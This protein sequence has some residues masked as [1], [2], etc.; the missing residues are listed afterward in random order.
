MAKLH[1]TL[2][3]E[4]DVET[5]NDSVKEELATRLYEGSLLN[6]DSIQNIIAIDPT[7]AEVKQVVVEVK[8]FLKKDEVPTL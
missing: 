6:V 1:V 3:F 7:K 2:E 4:V 8:D 5:A